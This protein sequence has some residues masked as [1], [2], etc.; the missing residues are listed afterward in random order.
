MN[1]L[2]H[3][4]IAWRVPYKRVYRRFKAGDAIHVSIPIYGEGC[5][6]QAAALRMSLRVP[7]RNKWTECMSA[8]HDCDMCP[9]NLR[10]DPVNGLSLEWGKKRIGEWNLLG[11]T[12]KPP[13]SV[14]KNSPNVRFRMATHGE[15]FVAEWC[16]PRPTRRRG[17]CEPSSAEVVCHAGSGASPFGT[18]I[19]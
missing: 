17:C 9:S 5:M 7:V 8:P 19:R 6:P 10:E 14:T 12:A 16:L 15:C 11:D 1:Q 18:S 3:L 4:P 13:Q 2:Y